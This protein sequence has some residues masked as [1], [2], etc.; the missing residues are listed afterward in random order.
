[1]ELKRPSWARLNRSHT[2][3]LYYFVFNIGMKTYKICISI[4]IPSPIANWRCIGKCL[5][6]PEVKCLLIKVNLRKTAFCIMWCRI[7]S[8]HFGKMILLLMMMISFLFRDEEIRKRLCKLLLMVSKGSGVR[9]SV[10]PFGFAGLV[11]FP[12]RKGRQWEMMF[13]WGL[14]IFSTSISVVR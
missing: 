13:G 6:A 7:T 9:W 12:D 3:V 5:S 11:L 8:Y 4:S 1:M 2:V 10:E 14:S